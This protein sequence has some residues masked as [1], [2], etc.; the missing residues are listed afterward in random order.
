MRHALICTMDADLEFG[1]IGRAVF[2]PGDRPHVD[3]IWPVSQPQTANTGVESRQW[4][5]LA[6]SHTTKRLR[7]KGHRVKSCK[8][9]LYVNAM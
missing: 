6:Y 3:L 5:V 9:I 8:I 1:Q 4:S 2:H 7:G